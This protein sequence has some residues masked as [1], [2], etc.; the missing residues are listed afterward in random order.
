MDQKRNIKIW[1]YDLSIWVMNIYYNICEFITMLQSSFSVDQFINYNSLQVPL[2]K[3][4]EWNEKIDQKEPYNILK[5]KR[6]DR[7]K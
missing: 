1:V 6:K 2:S 4:I 5:E 3:M 7:D